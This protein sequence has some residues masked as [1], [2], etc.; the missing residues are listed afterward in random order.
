[1][2]GLLG[3]MTSFP[4]AKALKIGSVG[5]V[6]GVLC[7]GGYVA[8]SRY[9]GLVESVSGLNK[10]NVELKTENG[11]LKMAITSKDANIKLLN[12]DISDRDSRIIEQEKSQKTL[13]LKIR[14]QQEESSHA[15]EQIKKILEG[16]QCAN[17]R[18]PDDVI[19]LQQQ[20]T[21]DFNK[22]F[23]G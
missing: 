16:S 15:V 8:Y 10:T 20:R 9:N 13:D 1:M 12:D 7:V 6:L 22:A 17:E 2:F 3:G 18:M 23:G 11:T 5:L 14:K 4:V 19:R 21:S